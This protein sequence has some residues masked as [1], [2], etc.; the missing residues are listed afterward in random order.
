[1]TVTKPVTGPEA[2]DTFS[3]SSSHTLD[4]IEVIFDE[5]EADM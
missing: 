2:E 4:A 3:M 1:M 5:Q